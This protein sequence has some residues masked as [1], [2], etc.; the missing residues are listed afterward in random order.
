M[1]TAIGGGYSGTSGDPCKLN[2]FSGTSAAMPHVAGTAALFLSHTDYATNED[3]SEVLLRTAKPLGS[4][5]KFGRGFLQAGDAL[6]LI[7]ARALV[8]DSTA[9]I[10][11]S[12]IVDSCRVQKFRNIRLAAA[13]PGSPNFMGETYQTVPAHL[14][15][16]ET[17]VTLDEH[18]DSG[19][20]I[21]AWVRG[22]QS[23]AA[24]DTLD[25][26]GY[27]EPYVGEVD[28]IG[29]NTVRLRGYTYE[30]LNATCDA[31]LGWYPLKL[32]LAPQSSFTVFSY[33]YLA[34]DTTSAR[35]LPGPRSTV[36]NRVAFVGST[37]G[38]IVFESN[39]A[40][41]AK[42]LIFDAGGRRLA[43]VA[44]HRSS[45]TEGRHVDWA[46]VDDSGRTLPSGHY[47]GRLEVG[48]EAIPVRFVVVR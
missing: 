25:Y 18:L 32:P 44:E 2:Y 28:S 45:G 23:I 3:I 4:P 29:W 13:V 33:S 17:T 36:S 15:R 10:G 24:R 43:T 5:L 16:Y 14:H 1:T 35:G 7:D 41:L 31:T 12:T 37:A 40:H 6:E 19:A 38:R 21:E 26:D 27:F 20:S 34:A 9:T 39:D 42:L 46:G 11:S 47:F 48:D 22:L 30:V 8:H